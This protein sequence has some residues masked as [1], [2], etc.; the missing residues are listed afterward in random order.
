[1]MSGKTYI[2]VLICC[3]LLV[4]CNNI[5]G[6]YVANH[7]DGNDTLRIYSDKYVRIYYPADKLKVYSDTGEWETK[8]NHI[9]FDNW[10][11]RS[12]V[13][14]RS[15]NGEAQYYIIDVD[16]SW[17][18]GKTKLVINYDLEYYYIKQ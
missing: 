16:R 11:N 14:D 2:Y 3:C 15:S 1:M 5:E 13:S 17:F 8:D 4:A 10:K 7:N 12:N 9:I 18:G 6:T